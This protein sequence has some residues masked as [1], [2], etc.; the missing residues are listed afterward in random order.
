MSDIPPILEPSQYQRLL[1]ISQI[2]TSTLDHQAILNQILTA[3]VELS[4][5]GEASILLYDE[6]TG[7]LKFEAVTNPESLPVLKQM[8]IPVESVAGWVA[9]NRQ[10]LLISDVSQDNRHYAQVGQKISLPT[11]SLIAVPMVSRGKLIGV[12]EVINKRQGHFDQKDLEII[13]ILSTQAAIAIQNARL[14][15]QSDLI[16]EFVHELRT[17]LTSVK[18][19]LYLLEKS[20]RTNLQS[21]NLFQTITSE[22]ERLNQLANDF[23]EYAR[24]ESGRVSFTRTYFHIQE[25]ISDCLQMIGT[26]ASEHDI[27]IFAN[28]QSDIPPILGDPAKIRQVLIN[29]LQNAVKYMAEPGQIDLSASIQNEELWIKVADNG[30]GIPEESLPHLFNKFY[31]APNAEK[32]TSGTGLGLSISKSIVE[33][34]QGTIFVESKSPQGTT[35][36]VRLPVRSKNHP[37]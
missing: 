1:E 19:A 30:I 6:T 27:Q 5:S 3:A 2:I 10:P 17:P 7:Q 31:R 20:E 26:L 9:S 24:L 8:D 11:Q 35:F 21:A 34:H 4:Q 36:M 28:I 13:N 29:L 25:V 23:L 22:V 12:L 32:I 14:F 33:A 37:D 16:S 18:T 15:E